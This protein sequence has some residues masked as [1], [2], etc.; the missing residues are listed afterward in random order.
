[1]PSNSRSSGRQARSSRPSTSSGMT[2]LEKGKG[3]EWSIKKRELKV[4]KEWEK[5]WRKRNGSENGA[6]QES[7]SQDDNLSENGVDLADAIANEKS[8]NLPSQQNSIPSLLRNPFSSSDSSS[9]S[10]DLDFSPEAPN[11]LLHHLPSSVTHAIHSEVRKIYDYPKKKATSFDVDPQQG[12]AE[13][14]VEIEEGEQ[15]HMHWIEQENEGEEEQVEKQR[16][17]EDEMDEEEND[18][19]SSKEDRQHKT[20]SLPERIGDNNEGEGGEMEIGEKIEGLEEVLRERV[21]TIQGV[22]EMEEHE[23]DEEGSEKRRELEDQ[24]RQ[25]LASSNLLDHIVDNYRYD[26]Y[27]DEEQ[28]MM[29]GVTAGDQYGMGI[30]GGLNSNSEDE[31]NDDSDSLARSNFLQQSQPPAPQHA[32][33]EHSTIN[34]DANLNKLKNLKKKEQKRRKREEKK[35]AKL[36]EELEKVKGEK[37]KAVDEVVST[38]DRG[39]SEKKKRKGNRKSEKGKGSNT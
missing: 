21:T 10:A 33:K 9:S 3:K 38:T 6:E 13:V 2:K 14:E 12:F 29:K 37:R 7:I 35:R 27:D 20:G 11:P 19:Y 28:E 23:E 4:M 22:V 39:L 8:L 34:E 5:E 32:T 17:L 26:C 36:A 25:T 18:D 31:E 1:M 16:K 24:L 30:E 15:K